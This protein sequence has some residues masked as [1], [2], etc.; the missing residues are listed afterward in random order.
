MGVEELGV[1]LTPLVNV[2]LC[3]VITL[4]SSRLDPSMKRRSPPER[5]LLSDIVDP[6]MLEAGLYH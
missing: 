1:I 2:L 3:A 6:L 5:T 4:A